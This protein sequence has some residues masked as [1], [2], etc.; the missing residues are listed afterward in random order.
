[1]SVKS[2]E[3]NLEAF[4]KSFASKNES[5]VELK[6]RFKYSNRTSFF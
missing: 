5:L 1:M 6:M 3:N 2:T 4:E